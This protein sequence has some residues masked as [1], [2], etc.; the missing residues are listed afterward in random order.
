MVHQVTG[1]D[2][3]QQPDAAEELLLARLPPARA[4][5]VDGGH[6]TGGA[7]VLPTLDTS[8]SLAGALSPTPAVGGGFPTLE[9][10][11]DHALF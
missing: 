8:A 2:D 11:W 3:L 6:A 1:A 10:S 4:A 7:L 5:V 9:S